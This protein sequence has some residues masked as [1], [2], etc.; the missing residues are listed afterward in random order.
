M[1][2]ASSIPQLQHAT[3]WLA[4]V[5]RGSLPARSIYVVA[6][7]ELPA[8]FT[9]M[10]PE[11]AIAYTSPILDIQLA[12]VLMSKNAWHGPGFATV[13][14]TERMKAIGLPFNDEVA[15]GVSAHEFCHWATHAAFLKS[16]DEQRMSALLRGMSTRGCGAKWHS[17]GPD[18][19]RACVH[20]FHRLV[21]FGWGGNIEYLAFAGQRY[22]MSPKGAYWDCV[23]REAE[24]FDDEPLVTTLMRPASAELAEL[25]Q[26]DFERWAMD[27]LARE[28]KTEAAA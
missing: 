10:A 4:L 12:D 16:N 2:R 14:L 19:A 13:V 22:A 9:A 17:H 1:S 20:V 23:M 8:E 15:T 7:T 18:F 25:W 3:H 28:P 6:D 24:R 21:R 26:E 27:V 5:G 11:G